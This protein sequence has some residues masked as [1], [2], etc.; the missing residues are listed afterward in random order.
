MMVSTQNSVKYY[1]KITG[2][3]TFATLETGRCLDIIRIP[4]TS[5]SMLEDRCKVVTKHE[6]DLRIVNNIN[7]PN[8]VFLTKP[9]T[10]HS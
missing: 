1:L 7:D 3:T 10:S 4:R 5:L 6:L 9:D 8:Q 2:L